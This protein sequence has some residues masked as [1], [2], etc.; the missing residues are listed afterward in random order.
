M[1]KLHDKGRRRTSWIITGVTVL[2]LG[3]ILILFTLT[4][5]DK[6]ESWYTTASLSTDGVLINEI[7]DNDF[8][9]GR[10][11]GIWRDIPDL[12]LDDIIDV[13]TPTANNTVIYLDERSE[14]RLKL[15]CLSEGTTCIRIGDP[16]ILWR[17]LHRY[18][19]TYKLPLDDFT[20]TGK[21]GRGMVEA[22]C[23]NAAPERW[24]YEITRVT[25]QIN[26]ADWLEKPQCR[27]GN[28][29]PEDGANCAIEQIGDTIVVIS[30]DHPPQTPLII[31]AEIKSGT[32]PSNKFSDSFILE[33]PP[34]P[35]PDQATFDWGDISWVPVI[36]GFLFLGILSS[37][38][39][40]RRKGRDVVK[41]GG[42]VEAAFA[43]SND[44]DS[45]PLSLREMEEMVTLSVVPPE[46]IEPHE[47]SI[48][49]YEKV[50]NSALQSWFLQQNI[51]GH[52]S[53]EGKSGEKLQYLS[54]I[55]PEKTGPHGKVLRDVFGRNAHE[56]GRASCRERV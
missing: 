28:K 38:F 43:D 8:G 42:A 55:E 21:C 22:F 14:S 34:L 45:K 10:N 52:I 9:N 50:T 23:W 15:G 41:V 56:I 31:S 35:T 19:L 40:V 39:L 13:S 48:L 44:V 46:G 17:G 3:A 33:P 54:D 25:A 27:V 11:R 4:K 47:A 26:N 12:S 49:L 37:T 20:A 51:T 30:L 5:D 7:I 24:A 29:A 2:V 32:S 16:D 1:G 53:I 18:E 6:T 36:L